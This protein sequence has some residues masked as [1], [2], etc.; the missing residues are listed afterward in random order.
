MASSTCITQPAARTSSPT[1][2]AGTAARNSLPLWGEGGGWSALRQLSDLDASNWQMSAAGP[3]A[4]DDLLGPLVG[5]GYALAITMLND[6]AAAE[7]AV[8]EAAI[9]AWR[10]LPTVRD[11]IGR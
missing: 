1:S 6:R 9:K 5:R 3:P 2:S 7:D 11:Q 4:F 8:Q 10:K